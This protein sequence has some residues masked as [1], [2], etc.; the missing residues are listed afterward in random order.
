MKTKIIILVMISFG[1][2]FL[3]SKS[4]AQETPKGKNKPSIFN[5]FCPISG[6]PV[7]PEANTIEFEGKVFG[8]CC[9]GCDTKFKKNPVKYASRISKDGKKFIGKP[10]KEMH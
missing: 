3:F 9:N 8:F 7:K 2:F 6:E 5:A 10:D 4:N 1:S